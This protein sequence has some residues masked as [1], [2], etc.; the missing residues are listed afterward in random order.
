MAEAD[1]EMKYFILLQKKFV[2][3]R[4]EYY[5]CP[6]DY[7]DVEK[8]IFLEEHDFTKFDGK[9][10]T[11]TYSYSEIIERELSSKNYH[12]DYSDVLLV[13]QPDLNVPPKYTVK[14]NTDIHHP[15][16]QKGGG[17]NV[18]LLLVKK[19]T[20]TIDAEGQCIEYITKLSK[21]DEERL[22]VNEHFPY[23]R[24]YNICHHPDGLPAPPPDNP[25]K[26]INQFTFEHIYGLNIAKTTL[27]TEDEE[28]MRKTEND[29]RK[30]VQ[31][32]KEAEVKKQNQTIEQEQEQDVP[33]N[34]SMTFANRTFNNLIHNDRIR[35]L[36][37]G[38]NSFFNGKSKGGTRK[39]RKTRKNKYKR[40]N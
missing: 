6:V 24:Y 8:R 33:R 3:G 34:T 20:S 32:E 30:K 22:R 2:D 19:R 26:Y 5:T 37:K 28:N 23:K 10:S 31:E 21:K 7:Q 40:C 36:N 25:N 11:Q 15:K 16:N 9:K 14:Y 27:T 29:A 17:C 4:K 35:S 1:I 13:L 18:Y 12:I 38:F 39:N